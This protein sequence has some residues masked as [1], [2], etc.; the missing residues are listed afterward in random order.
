MSQGDIFCCFVKATKKCFFEPP[1]KFV[2]LSKRQGNISLRG[3]DLFFKVTKKS[4]GT[5]EFSGYG[6]NHLILISLDWEPIGSAKSGKRSTL[7][8]GGY[9]HDHLIPIS[10]NWEPIGSANSGKRVPL[11]SRSYFLL[12]CQSDKI[13]SQG[14]IFCCFVKATKKCFFKSPPL[15]FVSLS[16]RQG[17]ISLRG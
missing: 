8:F 3:V 1:L 13:M 5:L 16:K 11:G 4:Q 6:H 9:R 12:L 15:K 7:G 10:F 17:N 2:S 14:A